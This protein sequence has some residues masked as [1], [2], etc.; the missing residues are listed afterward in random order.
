MRGSARVAVA[1]TALMLGAS[2]FT[3]VGTAQ[4]PL[5]LPTVTLPIPT[6]SPTTPPASTLPSLTAELLLDMARVEMP[7]EEGIGLQINADFPEEAPLLLDGL[8]ILSLTANITP[9]GEV[10]LGST[11]SAQTA[12][13]SSGGSAECSDDAFAP[14][15]FKWAADDM[16]VEW[17]VNRRSTP[18]EVDPDRTVGAIRAAHGIWT[19]ALSP[20]TDADPVTFAYDFAGRNSRHPDYDHVNTVDF[21]ALGQGALALNYTWYS[22]TNIVEVDL[23]LNKEDYMWT[24][25]SGVQ[26]YQ[27]KNV[28]THELGHQFGLGD[29]GDPHGALTMFGRIGKGERNKITLGSGD[30]RGAEVLSP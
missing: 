27:V 15:G 16:P 22:G 6:A 1:T 19:N 3:G 28:M 23:R 7:S 11:Q 8:E 2:L 29:L 17:F 10:V 26:K 12:A 5:P 13:S 24:N 20:C 4:V 14:T 25:I 21:G 18:E 30:I 9:E